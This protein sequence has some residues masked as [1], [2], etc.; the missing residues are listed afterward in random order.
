MKKIIALVLMLMMTFTLVAC[1]EK[2]KV[3][4]TRR[5]Y[6]AEYEEE[7]EGE[8]YTFYNYLILN[9]DHTGYSIVQDFVPVV[10]DDENVT[11]FQGEEYEYNVPYE[12]S[13][14]GEELTLTRNDYKELYIR[15]DN[16]ED[17]EKM[18]K[19]NE[20]FLKEVQVG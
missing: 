1:Q 12:I 14:D 7:L 19:E 16:N 15:Q 5:V 4:E 2:I 11:Y 8:A 3:D 9:E 13:E 6:V 18:I 10:W 20:D 17:I